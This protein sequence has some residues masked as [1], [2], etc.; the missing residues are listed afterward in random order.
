MKQI[1]NIEELNNLYIVTKLF[2]EISRAVFVTKEDSLWKSVLIWNKQKTRL[3]VN[4][5]VV[6]F[7]VL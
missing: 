1:A 4:F 2:F 7:V 5:N 3:K 6:F